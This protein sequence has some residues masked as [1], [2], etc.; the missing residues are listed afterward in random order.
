MKKTITIIISA[1]LMWG[2]SN[3]FLDV[4]NPSRLS[5]AV[6][7]KSIADM[8]QVVTAIYGQLT[9]QGL[10]GKRIFAKG[11]FVTDH[12][13]DMSWTADAY[14][15]QLTTNQITPDNTYISTLW[16]AFYKV[17]NCANTVLLEADRINT[18]DF[19]QEDK[20]RLDQMRGEALFWRGWAHQHLVT[21]W[22]EGFASNGDGG[23]Q[24]I[25]L[26]LEVASSPEKLNI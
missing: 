9:Q 21:L 1:I 17:I 23:K 5:P 8:E 16:F 19:S 10:Y 26:R 4:S 7:P 13:V 11:T 22:G 18:T 6:F 3:D 12:T 24:G 20:T 15:N 14:W 25:P 2:C